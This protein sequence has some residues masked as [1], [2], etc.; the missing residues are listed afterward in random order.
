MPNG[1]AIGE[2]TYG[3]I[4]GSQSNAST[5]STNPSHAT[6]ARRGGYCCTRGVAIRAAN[7]VKGTITAGRST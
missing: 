6:E 4:L 7:T 3:H 1:A 5:K 2:L